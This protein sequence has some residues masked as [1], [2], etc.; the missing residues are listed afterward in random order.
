MKKSMHP[1]DYA[2]TLEDSFKL[3]FQDSWYL[4]M[5]FSPGEFTNGMASPNIALTRSLVGRVALVGRDCADVTAVDG[6]C[7]VLLCRQGAARVAGFDRNDFTPLIE[8]V[9]K[10]LGVEFAYFPLLQQSEI[11]V[12]AR[13]NGFDGFDVVVNSGLLYHVFGPI[14]VLAATRSIVKTGGVLIVETA[15]S[16]APDYSMTFN[17]AGALNKVDATTFWYPS[18]RMLDYMLRMLRLLPLDLAFYGNRLAIACRAVRDVPSP[19]GDEWLQ[20][21]YVARDYLDLTDW[22]ILDRSVD[23][24]VGYSAPSDLPRLD[25]GGIDVWKA[26]SARLGYM[27]DAPARTSIRLGDT[28]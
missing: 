11:P 18:V 25:D 24:E 6:W 20:K 13:R 8:K 28:R 26:Y 16:T 3:R 2:T 7:L 15:V 10:K 27:P 9:R 5:E 4:I 1:L 23:G 14:N 12:A 22:T 21:T 17:A 19:A